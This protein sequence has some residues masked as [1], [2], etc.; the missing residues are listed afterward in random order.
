MKQTF[1][2]LRMLFLAVSFM[3][4]LGPM[5]ARAQ[6]GPTITQ[7]LTNQSAVLGSDVSFSVAVS[8]TGPFFY[9]WQFNSNNFQN[10]IATVAG[11]GTQN[12]GDG[13]P[14]TNAEL[15]F[16]N[17]VVVDAFGNLFIAD[18]DNN[19][20][21]EV[22]TNGIITTVAGNGEAGYSGDGDQ[23]TNASL[24]TPYGVAVDG[25]GN[26]FIA[27]FNNNCI[28]EVGTNGII[29]TVAGNGTEG[30]FGDGGPATNAN[31]DGPWGIA[32]DVSGNVYF[33]DTF[34]QRVREVGTNGIINTVAGNGMAGYSGDGVLA[35]NASLF[36]PYSVA[37]D[38][39][40]NLFVTDCGNQ[41]IR[42]VG[43]NGIINTVAG[44]GTDGY[45]GDGGAATNASLHYPYGVA[46]DVYGNLFIADTYNSLIREVGTNGIIN[47]VA[48][49]GENYPGDGGA[50][51]NASLN[52]PLGMAVDA[53]GDLFIADGDNNRIREVPSDT[54]PTLALLDLIAAD[55]SSYDVVVSNAYGSVTSSVVTLTVLFPPTITAQPQSQTVGAGSN[56]TFSVIASGTP[57]LYYQWF[58]DG[59]ALAGQ[60][61]SA[62]TLNAASPANTGSYQVVVTNLYGSATS[63]AATLT[64]LLIVTQPRSQ[65]AAVG[66]NVTFGVTVTATVPFNYQWFFDGT[67]LPGQTNS[68]LALNSVNLTNTGSYDVVVTNGLYG[69]AI[70]SVAT[71]TVGYPPALTE[72]PQNQ[73]V[74]A[75]NNATL[76][77]TVSGTGPF[78]YQ[79][80]ENGTNIPN[81]IITT[82][83]G[84]GENRYSGDG[85]KATNTTLNEP[86][87]VAVDAYGNLFIAD[88]LNRRIR[89]VGT[90]GIITTVA[91]NGTNGFY[92]DGGA[93]T[94]AEVSNPSGVAMDTSGNL[95]I[96]DTDNNRIRKVD[97][98]GTITT[99]AGDFGSGYNGDGHAATNTSLNHPQ[100][101]AIDTDDNLLIAD[102]S[103]QRVREATFGIIFTVA[104]GGGS[105]PGDGGAAINAM[106]EQPQ[107]VAVDDDGNLYIADTYNQRIRKVDENGI[108]TTV[109][110][111]GNN[112]PGDGG[113]ATN[114]RLSQPHGLALDISGNILIADTMNNR[115]RKI[116]TNGIITTV[117][118]GG[119]SY[120]G[121]GGAATNAILENPNGVAVDAYGNLFI[122]DTYHSRIR[123]V[124][125]QGPTF[126]V[127][128]IN[129]SATNYDVVVTSP[130]GSVT[131]S[132][133]TITEVFGPGITAPPQNQVAL[134]GGNA[135]FSV[136]A[137]GTGPFYYQWYF[138]GALLPD[139]TN[140]TLVLNNVNTNNAGDYQ[141]VVANL[142]AS[143]TSS[144]AALS[145]VAPTLQLSEE[146][147]V[148]G[149]TETLSVT[150]YGS[151][152][153]TYQWQH[154]GANLP[155]YTMTIVAG[156]GNSSPYPGDGGPATNAELNQ[157]W[158]VAVDAYGNL[159]IADTDNYRIREVG[160]N[161]IITTVAGNGGRGYSG[162]GGLA[163][164]ASLSYPA[165]VAVDAYGNLFIAD[166]S[167]NRI[168]KV[169]VNRIITTVAGGGNG[170]YSGDGGL[171]TN[172][173]LSQ[174]HGVALD[175]YGNLFIADT[176]NSRIRE[177]G[178]NGIIT[179]VAGNGSYG[180][181]GDGGAAI[182]ASLSYPRGVAVDAYGNL[183]IADTWN[184]RI[185]EVGVNRI[186]TTVAG[187]GNGGS[188]SL[189]TNASLSGPN[190][191]TVDAYGDL[192][193][194]DNNRIWE[195]EVGGIITSV[196]TG[197][198]VPE[199]V[200]ED[201][202]GNLFIAD[203]Y[204]NVVRKVV[205]Q[206]PSIVLTTW[207]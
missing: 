93:A 16:P 185:R 5:A 106:L 75:G 147:V 81:G 114:A 27:D 149:S 86:Y 3:V 133:A 113:A 102:T 158:S 171:A 42:E 77:V 52:D 38:A 110:G 111:G 118:G 131:S 60:T 169:G 57:P 15:N 183:F 19:R 128:N 196:A 26:L 76:S 100:G 124:N 84:N 203:S 21:R 61:N 143:V 120:P 122:A 150:V 200:A 173:V 195:A 88:T 166:T 79:W 152:P 115:I 23:A 53:S 8:G 139:Q 155:S 161:G 178:T 153:L 63:S 58:F 2:G 94:N 97:G 4:L 29:N 190:S 117:A 186:I 129:S 28:R 151:G 159:F 33:S 179:T 184:N 154:N 145:V 78:T 7:D 160:A 193:I 87:G 91:G 82:V 46:V 112:Y 41:R 14:A 36:G 136:T 172:A 104:G 157:P 73:T 116:S 189:A 44:D 119:N 18:S 199:G 17:S 127:T 92:G 66:S 35:T 126:L 6:T 96:A 205:F 69:S 49:G 162:D 80:Q 51:T 30:Y 168:R 206:G 31:L 134:V 176:D 163:T 165:G 95:F 109:A 156:G 99:V 25:Y 164:N 74:L 34:N 1:I 188:G 107:G 71:L 39:Y 180:Y 138:G 177:V 64:V 37:V 140:T 89:E 22:T 170:Y 13:G 85:G 125:I 146:P 175:A 65:V 121:D 123:K 12:P 45:S 47:T 207:W 101:I 187:G 192:F 191:V 9:Q 144:M 137:S 54:M 40:G 55:A 108:I 132:F 198:N 72:E 141:V 182:N 59:A 174:P 90:D 67:A 68:T 194:V 10:I 98:N 204:N 83:A 62:L 142:Y 43:T 105:N 56:A 167:N 20:I 70:S 130:Y 201:A 202:Y 103:N 197:F 135:I 32:V 181:S 24:D 48:G 148:A 50:A 11:G